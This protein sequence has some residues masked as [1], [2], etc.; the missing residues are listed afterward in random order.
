MKIGENGYKRTPW[1]VLDRGHVDRRGRVARGSTVDF[2]RRE[3]SGDQTQSSPLL[4]GEGP[5]VRAEQASETPNLPSNKALVRSPQSPIPDLSATSPHPNPLPKG[6]GTKQAVA[7]GEGT[8][9]ALP[10]GDGMKRHEEPVVYT[11]T[12]RVDEVLA[13]IQI[14]QQLNDEQSREY[15]INRLK[16]AVAVPAVSPPL[17]VPE[18][19]LPK[20]ALGAGTSD[21]DQ[22]KDKRDSTSIDWYKTDML[23]VSATQKGHW[24]KSSIRSNSFGYICRARSKSECNSSQCLPRF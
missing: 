6:E 10:K 11:V 4:L 2:G 3:T 5:R 20:N 8:R 16:V 19:L 21:R 17:E 15:L 22:P 7:K 13:R 24:R 1:V 23:V 12:Y 14:E 18:V 9:D